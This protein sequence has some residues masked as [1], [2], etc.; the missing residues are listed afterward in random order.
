[1]NLLGGDE[2]ALATVMRGCP[3][4][5][6]RR[7]GSLQINDLQN[8]FSSFRQSLDILMRCARANVSL[9]ARFSCGVDKRGGGADN[10]LP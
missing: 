9:A 4:I 10:A 8:Q 6:F 5:D 7:N 3:T 1:M 2:D